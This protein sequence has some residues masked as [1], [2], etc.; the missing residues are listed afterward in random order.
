MKT[1]LKKILSIS[2]QPGLFRF[3][4][5]AKSGVIAESLTD[6]KRSMYGINVRLTALSDISIYTEEREVP[7]HEVLVKMKE[8]LGEDDAPSSKSTPGQLKEF[9][10]TVIPD[11]DQQRFYV[12][13]M[14]KVV[15][16]YNILKV[17]ASLDFE[18]EDDKKD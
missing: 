11:Y 9:F 18:T 2:G 12:S 5:Q 6:K 16:W 17:H 4:S 13:H 15:E 8:L 10:L 3:I 14:K 1:D 7:L